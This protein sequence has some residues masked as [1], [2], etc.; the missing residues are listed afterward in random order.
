MTV[1]GTVTLRLLR[2]SMARVHVADIHWLYERSQR[3]PA[4]QTDVGKLVGNLALFSRA[5]TEKLVHN[6]VKGLKGKTHESRYRGLKVIFSVI[7][8]GMTMGAVFLKVTGRKRNPYNPL[9]IFAFRPG[10][11][12]WGIIDTVSVVYTSL[13]GASMGDKRALDS[14]LVGLTR[15]ADMW[16]PFYNYTLRGLEALTD[17]KNLDRKALRQMR[18]AIDSEYG[19]REGAYKVNRT[20]VEAW[21]YFLAGGGV[22]RKEKATKRNTRGKAR[23]RTGFKNVPLR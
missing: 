15:L 1:A 4:E 5:Y 17:Q 14:F 22:D 12:A 18:A 11:L 19:I 6:A 21:Q 16:I 10:G 13:L 9:R 8:G 7:V 3:S 23:P 2:E 20:A